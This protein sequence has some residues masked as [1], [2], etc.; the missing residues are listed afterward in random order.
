MNVAFRTLWRWLVPHRMTDAE[1]ER[2]LIS[3]QKPAGA[4][5]SNSGH[6]LAGEPVRVVTITQWDGQL[7]K[8]DYVKWRDDFERRTAERIF[9]MKAM[10]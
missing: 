4:I 7:S 10:G 9:S 2:R 3:G 1:I 8:F 5:F 6:L